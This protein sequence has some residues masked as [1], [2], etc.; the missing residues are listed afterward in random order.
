[1]FQQDLHQAF[2]PK[3][4]EG[5]RGDAAVVS[6]LHS[7]LEKK[8]HRLAQTLAQFFQVG[9]FWPGL[10][11]PCPACP[12][13]SWPGLAWPGTA[14]CSASD[15]VQDKS[16][17]E[18]HTVQHTFIQHLM[19]KLG[20]P[21]PGGADWAEAI[22][23]V[24]SVM[25]W[26]TGS[27]GGQLEVLCEGLWAARGGPL[28]EERILSCLLRPRCHSLISVYCSTARRLQRDLLLRG[29]PHIQGCASGLM[30]GLVWAW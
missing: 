4:P 29:A 21:E 12:V 11:C 3:A 25:P 16:C 28:A 19:R 7:L 20:A 8:Q 10:V 1:M 15:S 17:T 24:L 27:R 18:P 2:E 6:C 9:Q 26:S 13:L 14:H 30:L 5:S 22:Y 23:A